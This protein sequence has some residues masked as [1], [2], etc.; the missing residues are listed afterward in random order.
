MENDPES[1]DGFPRL[2]SSQPPSL[3]KKRCWSILSHLLLAK[4]QT[5]ACNCLI[6]SSIGDNK[7]MCCQDFRLIADS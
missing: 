6:Y 3:K 1:Y 7:L 2:E 4:V 5:T